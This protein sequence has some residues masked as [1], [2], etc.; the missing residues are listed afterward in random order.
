ME[1]ISKAKKYQQKKTKI[2]AKTASEQQQ[3]QHHRNEQCI[4]YV[5]VCVCVWLYV[6]TLVLKAYNIVHK[7][8][9]TQFDGS[10]GL[11]VSELIRWVKRILSGCFYPVSRSPS[12]ILYSV[13][14]LHSLFAVTIYVLNN[15]I[16]Y[17]MPRTK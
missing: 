16:Q 14:Y 17:L 7:R 11:L 8:G 3:Q 10:V 2:K 15:L 12:F 4:L 5:S 6:Q 1:K 9:D 13:C